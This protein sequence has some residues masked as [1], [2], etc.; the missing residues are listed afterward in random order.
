MKHGL[1]V[2]T[3]SVCA[4]IALTVAACGSTGGNSSFNL[5]SLFG[6]G[7]GAAI[8]TQIGSGTGQIAAVTIGTLA[9][10]WVGTKI[11]DQL[12][13][14]ERRKSEEAAQTALELN[15]PSAWR[16][17]KTGHSGT[18][19]PSRQ[20]VSSKG[21]VCKEFVQT[22]T[23]DG[24]EEAAVGHACKDSDNSWRIV[25]KNSKQ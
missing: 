2:K 22:I 3:I 9:G 17:E 10:A 18:I 13:Y 19:K 21:E 25:E 6:G 12:N 14:A 15:A 7:V 11:V 5:G 8:G 20:Y 4:A 23:V 16:N 1:Q 24:K